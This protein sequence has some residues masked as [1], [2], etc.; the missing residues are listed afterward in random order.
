LSKRKLLMPVIIS[1]YSSTNIQGHGNEEE[2]L[3]NTIDG[4]QIE[5]KKKINTFRASQKKS[6]DVK[7]ESE[8]QSVSEEKETVITTTTTS[9]SESTSTSS[10]SSGTTISA[11]T[12]STASSTTPR[13]TSTPESSSSVSGRDE[14]TTAEVITEYAEER[15]E[16]ERTEATNTNEV[17]DYEQSP[18]L[19]NIPEILDQDR[20]LVLGQQLPAVKASER[21]SESR[22][23][24]YL[25]GYQQIGSNKKVRFPGDETSTERGRED[26]PA[27][28]KQ[29]EPDFY[30]LGKAPK[31]K[32]T[33]QGSPPIGK[34]QVPRPVKLQPPPKPPVKEPEASS[35]FFDF[36][37]K[38]WQSSNPTP[39][40]ASPVRPIGPRRPPPPARR[41]PTVTQLEQAPPPADYPAGLAAPLLLKVGSNY[42]VQETPSRPLT[43]DPKPNTARIDNRI[44][45]EGE[46]PFVVLPAAAPQKK[47]S[48][49]R[50]GPPPPRRPSLPKPSGRP[51]GP[52]SR[53]KN[54]RL[55][56]GP[57]P[58][59]SQPVIGLPQV[60]P[61]RKQSP[62]IAKR[63]QLPPRV[64]GS[65]K[66]F[67]PPIGP[68]RKPAK[69]QKKL[70]QKPVELRKPILKKSSN[71]A[72]KP[73][74]GSVQ[75]P[76]ASIPEI[77]LRPNGSKQPG[78]AIAN[79]L[80]SLLTS[81]FSTTVSPARPP[82]ALPS[83]VEDTEFADV[84]NGYK[85]SDTSE[86][87]KEAETTEK[88]PTSSKI[89]A[90]DEFDDELDSLSAPLPR[91]DV[92]TRLSTL[93]PS[94]PTTVQ[95][96]ST[97]IRSTTTTTTTSATEKTTFKA[98]STTPRATLPPQTY[99]STTFIAPIQE[100]VDDYRSKVH[101]VP[102]D[103]LDS[104]VYQTLQKDF[105]QK[106]NIFE[107]FVSGGAVA[108]TEVD[109]RF[110]PHKEVYTSDWTV[111]NGG[112][113]LLSPPNPTPLEER[114]SLTDKV[115]V[116]QDLTPV[117]TATTPAAVVSTSPSS[118]PVASRR[119]SPGK[120]FQGER[121]AEGGFRPMIPRLS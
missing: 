73:A 121:N 70:L 31:G 34:K 86:K 51:F 59:T 49:P 104:S 107:Q 69:P 4:D 32:I 92:V 117:T 119:P 33:P 101:V 27:P 29:S 106:R 72:L 97:T 65:N 41:V 16:E 23:S 76:S 18:Y 90:E 21:S 100:I 66:V 53:P 102:Q 1:S 19:P 25:A 118:S 58:M 113:Q 48:A 35:S 98:S 57:L 87:A 94:V 54:P 79:H 50:R 83:L 2:E 28:P 13:P 111:Q 55:G 68:H 26:R 109:K 75:Q 14:V 40:P 120:L 56:G 61:S 24:Q 82:A 96:K 6:G 64:P 11:S 47:A 60:P 3:K 20:I 74:A 52:G 84:V 78:S 12:T 37:P 17:P 5:E 91:N 77:T 103:Q 62:F 95:P 43:R 9:S 63:P 39:A 30:P 22:G 8:K 88:Q 116:Y 7:E 42:P 71:P 80:S 115:L 15:I 45:T 99:P 85:P 93:S 10:P 112:G 67:S 89:E 81:F 46:D 110:T 114:L 105:E 38:F 108:F 36:F 44:Y